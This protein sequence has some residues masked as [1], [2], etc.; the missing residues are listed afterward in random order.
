METLERDSADTCMRRAGSGELSTLFWRL[1]IQL[2]PRVVGT[3]LV[4]A[5]F[6]KTMNDSELIAVLQF[7]GFPAWSTTGRRRR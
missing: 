7:D 1:A 6:G 5:A 2:G 3:V 4:L